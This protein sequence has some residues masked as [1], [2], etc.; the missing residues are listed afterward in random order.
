MSASFSCSYTSICCVCKISGMLTLL[1]CRG[2]YRG[3]GGC[4]PPFCPNS[5]FFLH[6]VLGGFGVYNPL[7]CPKASFF[8]TH[9]D[10]APPPPPPPPPPFINNPPL[11]KI[12]YPP[13]HWLGESVHHRY[14][15]QYPLCR[16]S[17][18]S[19]TYIRIYTCIIC[20]NPSYRIHGEA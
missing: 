20:I 13:L 9:A 10:S 18:S 12:L 11:S 19:L 14:R 4:N 6:A 7:F 17:L 3:F 2:G 16:N 8:C 15:C 1:H 5:F